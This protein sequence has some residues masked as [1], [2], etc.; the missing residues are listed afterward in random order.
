MATYAV[1]HTLHLTCTSMFTHCM[2]LRPSRFI[3]CGSHLTKF[4]CFYI[5][6]RYRTIL[7]YWHCMC[8]AATLQNHGFIEDARTFWKSLCC[9]CIICDMYI[10]ES[11]F[12]C[13][14]IASYL[15]LS[16]SLFCSNYFSH[17]WHR[18]IYH[19][20]FQHCL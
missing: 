12:C 3:I 10:A 16:E 2:W 14:Y 13:I 18:I 7:L 4:C 15:Y 5:A 1:F 20:Y 11:F 17:D 8:V 9:L 6:Y 19:S